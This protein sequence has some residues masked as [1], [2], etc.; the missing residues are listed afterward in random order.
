MPIADTYKKIVTFL[1]KSL[2]LSL[3][4]RNTPNYDYILQGV[5]FTFD[6]LAAKGKYF[7]VNS[8][9]RI[10]IEATV[11]RTLKQI[12]D[13]P[14]RSTRNLVDMALNFSE[15]RFQQHFFETAQRMLKNEHSSYYQMIPDA[16]STIDTERIITFGMNVG[17]NS[18]TAGANIIRTLESEEHFSIPWSITLSMSGADYINRNNAYLS[19]IEQGRRWEFTHGLFTFP[20][21]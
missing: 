18:C 2:S 9:N 10:L 17:Y 20:M 11:R 16:I 6:S 1:D 7:M 8:L 4:K 12:K 5:L 19:L 3:V 21:E 15:G 13:D 14:K